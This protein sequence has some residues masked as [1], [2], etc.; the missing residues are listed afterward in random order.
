MINYTQDKSLQVMPNTSFSPQSSVK[1]TIRV[2]CSVKLA[3]FF[4]QNPAVKWSRFK[5]TVWLLCHRSGTVQA[6]GRNC[7]TVHME[8]VWLLDKH[9]QIS[10]IKSVRNS[11][12]DH[13]QIRF[14]M[15]SDFWQASFQENVSLLFSSVLMISMFLLRALKEQDMRGSEIQAGSH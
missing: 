12:S 4:C 6:Y 13:Q 9:A 10:E 7:E 3:N 1:S 14:K 8:A 15:M 11:V 2:C 5:A